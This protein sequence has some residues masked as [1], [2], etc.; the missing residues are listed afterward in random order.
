M[1]YVLHR[2]RPDL[3]SPR[4]RKRVA[5]SLRRLV[6]SLSPARLPGASPL[7]RPAVRPHAARL[8]ALA[9]QLEAVDKPVSAA[10]VRAVQRLLADPD[11]PLYE[12]ERATE[13]GHAIERALRALEAR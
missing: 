12:R 8:M 3:T 6:D 5:R 11:G 1:E 13:V 2:P 7:N 9:R 10:G 4:Q